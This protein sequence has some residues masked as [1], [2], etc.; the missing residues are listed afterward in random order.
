MKHYSNES[1]ASIITPLFSFIP[2]RKENK[3]DKIKT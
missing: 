3:S 2:E 1:G